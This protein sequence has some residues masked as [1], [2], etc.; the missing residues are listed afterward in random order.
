MSLKYIPVQAF[1]I[2]IDQ[3]VKDLKDHG[4][5]VLV[6]SRTHAKQVAA[7]ASDKLDIDED[8][9]EGP[10]HHHL[11]FE[12]DDRGWEDCL[13]YS[14]SAGYELDDLREITVHAIRDWIAA[15]EK[16]YHVCKIRT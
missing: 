1:D 12:V 8:D 16:G 5:V 2:D 9:E 6:T 15:G 13:V 3:V 7:Q 11:S 10:C 4:V 14:E